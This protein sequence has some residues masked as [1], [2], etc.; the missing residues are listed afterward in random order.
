MKKIIVTF[1]ILC[2]FLCPIYAKNTFEQNGELWKDLSADPDQE[3][4]KLAKLMYVRGIYDGIAFSGE[5]DLKKMF[6]I[7]GEGKKFYGNL[8]E[9]L[10]EFYSDYRNINISVIQAL[11][12]ISAELRG[13]K[14]EKIEEL[15][16]ETR[17][18][19]LEKATIK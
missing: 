18:M 17:K 10:D 1:T 9:A 12:I 8:I 16:E 7:E 19:N 5:K 11:V 4:G 15:K 13:A 14:K 2:F 6:Y 3:R